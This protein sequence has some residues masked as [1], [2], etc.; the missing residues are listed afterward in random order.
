MYIGID[1]G[2]THQ[3][4]LV[5]SKEG[6]ILQIK[7]EKTPK[8]MDRNEQ[9][10]DL[11]KIQDF[12]FGTIDVLKKKFPIDGISISSIGESVVP[13]YKGKAIAYPLLWHDLCTKKVEKKIHTMTKNYAP[14]SKVGVFGD[15]T[16]SL[17]KILW[18]QEFLHIDQVDYWL[19]ISSYFVFLLT[20]RA[21][22]SES[23]ACR[24]LLF[25]V[26]TREWITE[27][28]SSVGILG[29]LGDIG[30][31]GSVVGST[32]DG[33]PIVLS[34]HDHITG[35]FGIQKINKNRPLIYQSMGTSAVLATLVTDI[36]SQFSCDTLL[37]KDNSR[38]IGA[39]FTP[40]QYFIQSS[41]RHFGKLVQDL[42]AFYNI[43]SSV[44]SIENINMILNDKALPDKILPLSF[45]GD[46]FPYVSKKSALCEYISQ[47]SNI[48]ATMQNLYIYLAIA[49]EYIANGLYQF[50]DGNITYFGGG[51]F[52]E[53]NL[54]MKYQASI[55]ERPIYRLKSTEV[56]A[57]G[58]ALAAVDGIGKDDIRLCVNGIEHDIIEP[59]EKYIP[60]MRRYKEQYKQLLEV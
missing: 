26:Y 47:K 31:T 56:T 12:I 50:L 30:Y 17:Y 39:A 51:G 55:L 60:N 13:V 44:K 8:I 53:N 15:Y 57:L 33:I 24:S 38:K 49:S 25:N 40:D 34:G 35:L 41:F 16:F 54:F 36:H 18:M 14:Y 21:V 2:T 29:D 45:D 59:I 4:I 37:T 48:S 11:G 7:R 27:L 52:A 3:K 23:H 10:F 28:I 9:Y 22:W 19:P 6:K 1:I 5:L 20:G 43:S 42:F 46:P 58:A 32:A